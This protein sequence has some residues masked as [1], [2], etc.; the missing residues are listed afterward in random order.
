MS[1]NQNAPLTY[2]PAN[3][4]DLETT[5][6]YINSLFFGAF[7][8]NRKYTLPVC[9]GE[10][11]EQYLHVLRE[12]DNTITKA[13]IATNA[14]A[15]DIYIT[16]LEVL[17]GD[18]QDKWDKTLVDNLIPD[19]NETLD[20]FLTCRAVLMSTILEEDAAENQVQYLQNTKKPRRLKV[21]QW[22]KRMQ[23]INSYLPL[24]E[25]IRQKLTEI[26]LI[27]WCIAPNLPPCWRAEFAMVDGPYVTN[28]LVVIQHLRAI[29]E[30]DVKDEE[31]KAKE[32][33]EKEKTTPTA[34]QKRK[35]TE[36]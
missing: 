2:D 30:R 7:R 24:M 14:R 25:Q 36:R 35:A 11:E 20:T 28:M 23:A 31:D 27:K 4:N 33:E 26:Q 8:S 1:N 34:K 15:Q 29:E 3:Q 22:I 12:F 17:Q 18:A 10:S 13:G 5:D 32:K 9:N 6:V 19:V 21:K 16:F